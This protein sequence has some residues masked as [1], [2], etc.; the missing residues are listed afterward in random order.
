[1]KNLSIVI[2]SFNNWTYTEKCIDSIFR[3]T[4]GNFEIVLVDNASGPETR[5]SLENFSSNPNIKLIFNNEN[6][7]FGKGNNIGLATTSGEYIILL[8]NDTIVTPGWAETLIHRIDNPKVGLVGPVTN[9]IGNEAKVDVCYDPE[10]L[11]DLEEKA[12]EYTTKHKGMYLE[13]ENIAA[14]C[15]IM[16]RKTY[17]QIGGFDERFGKAFFEDDDYCLRVKKAG[18]KILIAEDVFVHHFHS[19]STGPLDNPGTK[20]L[21]LENKKKF[22]DKWGIR[23]QPHQY[24]KIPLFKR[25]LAK[26]KKILS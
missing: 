5:K 25:L 10:D 21:F 14:F 19:A 11:Q 26:Y 24:R 12:A 3:N 17:E 22:E 9:S 7:G 23:W 6:Y 13:V 16:K 20:E 2:L 1:M 15:W 18:L 8:N 4:T